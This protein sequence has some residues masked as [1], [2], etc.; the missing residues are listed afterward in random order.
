MFL[1]LIILKY[2]TKHHYL[3]TTANGIGRAHKPGKQNRKRPCV[4]KNPSNLTSSTSQSHDIIN[5]NI[6]IRCT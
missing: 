6:D 5:E 1:N 4:T 3:S 2:E